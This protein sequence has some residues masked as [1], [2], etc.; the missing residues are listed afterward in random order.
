MILDMSNIPYD[1]TDPIF[2]VQSCV[3]KDPDLTFDA[4]LMFCHLI[5]SNGFRGGWLISDRRWSQS[6]KSL[7]KLLARHGYLTLS[8]DADGLIQVGI[9]F[10][11]E[12]E[13]TDA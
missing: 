2:H 4:K 12:T 1:S 5:C 8:Q 11:G 7:L 13:V 9:V 6:E 10:M 3:L